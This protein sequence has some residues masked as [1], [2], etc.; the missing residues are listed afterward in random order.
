MKGTKLDKELL[1][2]KKLQVIWLPNSLDEM[3]RSY[4][5]QGNKLNDLIICSKHK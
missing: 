4:K 5:M 1:V 3:L 2:K